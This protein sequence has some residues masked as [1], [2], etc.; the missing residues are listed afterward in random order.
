MPTPC[1]MSFKSWW[2][3]V[4]ATAEVQVRFPHERHGNA[5]KTSNSALWWKEFV[6]IN[7]QPNGRSS[8]VQ[9]FIFSRSLPQSRFQNH[10]LR[11]LK[12]AFGSLWVELSKEGC[13]AH[14]WV[15]TKSFY[16]SSQTRLLWHL[17]W[18]VWGLSKQ[19]WIDYV[20]AAAEELKQI[21]ADI[22]SLNDSDKEHREQAKESHV[23]H[24][25]CTVKSKEQ[26][27]KISEL[28]VVI[29]PTD[30]VLKHNYTLT[31]S[32][33]YQMCR[34][35]WQ[36]LLLSKIEP[37]YFWSF[38]ERVFNR[39]ENWTQEYRSYIVVYNSLPV[40]GW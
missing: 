3:E 9:H 7:S 40:C 12:N 38:Y 17:R 34:S 22:K 4:D 13:T 39:W 27:S 8:D 31:L 16:L 18:S 10:P 24:L 2:M 33:D 14:N 32:A 26:M 37:W 11:T 20:K 21:E 35:T 23:Y 30:E 6:D 28:E 29:S 19:L 15:Q 5:G 36:H 1:D 25:Q